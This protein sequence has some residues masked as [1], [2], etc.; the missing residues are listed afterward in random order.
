M[1]AAVRSG[2]ALRSAV[3]RRRRARWIQTI[4][5]LV[6]FAGA[7]VLVAR[8]AEALRVVMLCAGAV[9]LLVSLVTFLPAMELRALRSDV[10]RPRMSSAQTKRWA[11]S[12]VILGAAVTAVVL[13]VGALSDQWLVAAG[14][15]APIAL[16]SALWPSIVGR[17]ARLDRIER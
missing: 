3:R 15:A 9:G 2:T 1:G 6:L 7:A 16:L 17:A 10:A 4:S 12:G 14:T 11:L 5:M 8:N 13:L